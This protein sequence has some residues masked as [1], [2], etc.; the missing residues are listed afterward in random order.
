M[1]LR[2]TVFSI[3]TLLALAH[4]LSDARGTDSSQR[5]TMEREVELQ[6]A[7]PEFLV[8]HFG[9]LFQRHGLRLDIGKPER[10][11]ILRGPKGAQDFVWAF[12]LVNEMDVP[13]DHLMEFEA[14]LEARPYLA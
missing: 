9:R 3:A 7:S 8:H 1:Q 11:V 14:R 4:D 5:R 2:G 13:A 6:K 10:S 12:I